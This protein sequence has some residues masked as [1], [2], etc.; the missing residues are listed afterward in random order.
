MRDLIATAPVTNEK[1]SPVN[2]AF[3]AL[4]FA[5][6]EEEYLKKLKAWEVE[7]EGVEVRL[8]AGEKA[9][10]V[11][12]SD[13]YKKNWAPV[14]HMWARFERRG[15]PLGGEHTT[16]RV[17]RTFGV[18]KME[19]KMCTTGD[20]SIE[21]AVVKVLRWAERKLTEAFA[22][23]QRKD[24]QIHD[25]DPI[26]QQELRKAALEL[27]QTGCRTFKKSLDAM[28]KQELKMTIMNGGV[29]EVLRISKELDMVMEESDDEGDEKEEVLEKVYE[30]TEEDCSC[31]NWHQYRCPC[32]HI[33]FFR[34]GRD[35]PLFEKTNFVEYYHL[36]RTGDLER[37]GGNEVRDYQEKGDD[38]ASDDLEYEE[39]HALAP[40]E[41]YRMAR[42]CLD[43]LRELVCQHG[44]PQFL[45][46]IWE[47]EVAKRRARRGLSLLTSNKMRLASPSSEEVPAEKME[48]K[49]EGSDELERYEFLKKV[50]TRG[51]PKHSGAGKLMFPKHDKKA[52]ER[53]EKKSKAREPEVASDADPSQGQVQAA[54]SQVCLAPPVPGQWGDN[55]VTLREYRSL[56][57]KAFLFDVVVNWWL[58]VL[59]HQYVVLGGEQRVL[60][61]STEC[62]VSLERSWDIASGQ[63]PSDHLKNW[64]EH[65]NLW[66]EQ[67]SRLVVLP[68]CHAGHY[69]TL[70]AVLDLEQPLLYV[71][72]SIGGGYAVEPPCGAQ[73]RALLLWLRLKAGVPGPDFETAILSVPRQ[74]SGSNNCGLFTLEYIEK[75]LDHPDYFVV[76]AKSRALGN[77]FS[78]QSVDQ[79]REKLAEQIRQMAVD[80]RLPGGELEGRPEPDLTLTAPGLERKQEVCG[81]LSGCFYYSYPVQVKRGK[82]AAEEFIKVI[83]YFREYGNNCSQ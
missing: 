60:V 25:H 33:L 71:L 21:M 70:V 80:Q 14:R 13:Y 54:D 63:D 9:R 45:E 73:F 72:E 2:D 83:F 64:V 30:T 40:E 81:G 39:G 56:A 52:K 16:N 18:L 27:N 44:T 59:V 36:E 29:K 82:G 46:Y 15:L 4:V 23:A 37:D 10:Y 57:P 77:W 20:L 55:V 24:M 76:L 47:M 32:R 67:G 8:G 17:E 62:A 31:T 49:D 53:K 1:K 69:Y 34:K 41:K 68:T 66:Q 43:E 12:L 3:R 75:I 11:Q 50:T 74:R 78:V 35:L 28:R 51:R 48:V 6:N 79:K 65:G 19:L 61:L 38:P 7:I 26:V 58:R 42:D 22:T 5:K